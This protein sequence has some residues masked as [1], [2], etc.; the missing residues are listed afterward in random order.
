MDAF[1]E[2]KM[3]NGKRILEVE[4][5]HL[6]K[7]QAKKVAKVILQQPGRMDDALAV[8]MMSMSAS[9][10]QEELAPQPTAKVGDILYASWGY[11]QT[12]VDFYEVVEVSGQSATIRKIS[13]HVVADHTYSV[14]VM[15]NP[16]SFV[17]AP[18]KKRVQK[19]RGGKY[20]IKVNGEYAWL[21][22]GKPKTETASGYGH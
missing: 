12:N 22:E 15:P 11:E 8:L 7:P 18:K 9:Q 2:G 14:D 4:R 21:W 13:R 20:E 1:I 6:S 17:G 16:G 19:S 10:A 5:T 3:V